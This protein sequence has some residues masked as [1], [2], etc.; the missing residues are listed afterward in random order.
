MTTRAT[1]P[2]APPPDTD[3]ITVPGGS[4]TDE[5][6]A[7]HDPS[8]ASLTPDT[9]VVGGEATVTVTGTNFRDDSVVEADQ[10]GVSTVYVSDTELTATLDDPGAAGT[11]SLSVRNPIQRDG[12]EQRR[13]HLD[14][15]REPAHRPHPRGQQVMPTDTEPGRQGTEGHQAVRQQG[16]DHRQDDL[17]H[18]TTQPW[19]LNKGSNKKMKVKGK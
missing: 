11:D 6:L 4:P 18:G 13:V 19:D 1:S 3:T 7:L 5:I 10:V 8:I 14:R 12:V 16:S 2:L 17:D 15:S 9:A